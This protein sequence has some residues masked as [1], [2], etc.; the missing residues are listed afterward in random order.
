M[1]D[2]KPAAKGLRDYGAVGLSFKTEGFGIRI[3]GLGFSAG[4]KI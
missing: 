3:Q 1:E 2:F 4:C